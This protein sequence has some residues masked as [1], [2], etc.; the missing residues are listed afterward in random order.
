MKDDCLAWLVNWLADSR[1]P[2][3]TYDFKG[4]LNNLTK[5]AKE[6]ENGMKNRINRNINRQKKKIKISV[7]VKHIHSCIGKHTYL[8]NLHNFNLHSQRKAELKKKK[9]FIQKLRKQKQQQ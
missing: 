1:Q 4:L 2:T 5:T 9:Y 3:T 6:N 8:S 7:I